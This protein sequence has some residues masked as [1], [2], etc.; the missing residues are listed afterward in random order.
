M[1]RTILSSAPATPTILC[2][3]RCWVA[4]NVPAPVGFV[5]I[6]E[7]VE[8]YHDG[9]ESTPLHEWRSPLRGS[10]AEVALAAEDRNNVFRPYAMNDVPT[11]FYPH[12]VGVLQDV[13]A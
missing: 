11:L 6:P 1:R 10:Y 3:L 2:E 12:P 8:R 4:P 7:R 5:R 13:T 9:R